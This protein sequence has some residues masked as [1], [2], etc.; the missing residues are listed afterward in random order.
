MW[1]ERRERRER[2]RWRKKGE[3]GKMRCRRRIGKNGERE[4]RGAETG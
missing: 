2:E 4:E 1:R 3:W